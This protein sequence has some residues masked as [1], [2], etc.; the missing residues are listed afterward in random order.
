MGN[1]TFPAVTICFDDYFYYFAKKFQAE[2][3]C[4]NPELLPLDYIDYAEVCLKDGLKTDSSTESEYFGNLFS[5]YDDK[6]EAQPFESMNELLEGLRLNVT[7]VIKFFNFG[8]RIVASGILSPKER[9]A[10]IQE[11]WKP[12]IE[13]REGMCFTF[14]PKSHELDL[15]PPNYFMGPPRKQAL[16]L[17][18]EF[19]VKC[20]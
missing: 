17:N 18:I 9:V 11:F 4:S 1:I 15:V 5:S 2:N 7:D 19:K 14:D 6:I 12:T 10:K 8:N 16:S 20:M 13:Y 3:K